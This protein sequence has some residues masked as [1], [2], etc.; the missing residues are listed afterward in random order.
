MKK[1]FGVGSVIVIIA[2]ILIVIGYIYYSKKPATTEGTDMT[3]TSTETSSL[4]A[5]TQADNTAAV[6]ATDQ[7]SATTT[8]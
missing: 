7:V 1:G 5:D 3:A 6:G 4:P 8:Q 2:I